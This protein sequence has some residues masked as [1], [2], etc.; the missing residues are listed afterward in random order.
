MSS[1][2][3][4]RCENGMFAVNSQV[5]IGDNGFDELQHQQIGSDSHRKCRRSNVHGANARM[6]SF[7]ANYCE[8]FHFVRVIRIPQ[9]SMLTPSMYGATVKILSDAI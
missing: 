6:Q 3:E 1:H 2:I 7:T 5:T 9:W 4:E 8:V